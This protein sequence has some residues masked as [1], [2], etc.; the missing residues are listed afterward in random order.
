MMLTV[1]PEQRTIQKFDEIWHHHSDISVSV[2]GY[3]FDNDLG[4]CLCQARSQVGALGAR[5]PLAILVH[6]RHCAVHP[7]EELKFWR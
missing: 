6:P 4:S 7:L 5:A 3:G 1:P 2:V